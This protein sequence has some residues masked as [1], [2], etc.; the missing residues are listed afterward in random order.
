MPIPDFIFIF[1][2]FWVS[3][4]WVIGVKVIEKVGENVFCSL[5]YNFRGHTVRE[6]EV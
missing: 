1:L 4:C 3:G 2:L 6:F 5:L